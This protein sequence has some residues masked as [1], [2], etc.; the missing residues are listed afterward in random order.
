MRSGALDVARVVEV[1][2]GIVRFC[3]ILKL[4][5]YQDLMMDWVR[6]GREREEPGLSYV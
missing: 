6:S 4:P 2:M 5:S 3:T 1:Q